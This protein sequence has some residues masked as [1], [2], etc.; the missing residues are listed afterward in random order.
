MAPNTLAYNKT[1][2][3]QNKQ[4]II[5]HLGE[6]RL[7]EVCNRNYALYNLSRHRKSIKHIKNLEKIK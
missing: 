7:C 6:Q 5:A 1:Y 4:K 3:K 2:Y